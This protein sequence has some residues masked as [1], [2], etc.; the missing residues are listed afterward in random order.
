[1]T[2]QLKSEVGWCD[3]YHCQRFADELEMAKLTGVQRLCTRCT[4]GKVNGWFRNG[5]VPKRDGINA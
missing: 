5:F 1:M 3:C 4:F 2:K